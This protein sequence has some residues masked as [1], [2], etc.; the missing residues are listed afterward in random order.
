M[1]PHSE[2][3]LAQIFQFFKEF[4]MWIYVILIIVGII[5]IGQ[6]LRAWNEM[7]QAAFG[8][9]HE[10]AQRRLNRSATGLLLMVMLAAVEFVVVSFIIPIVPDASPLLLTPTLDVL[11]TPTTTLLPTTPTA[12]GTPGSDDTLSASGT[13]APLAAGTQTV[14]CNPE[15]IN[16]SSPAAGS[17]VSG[18]VEIQG[19]ADV[20]NFG[21]YKFEF[22]SPGQPN[23]QAILAWTSPKRNDSLGQWDTSRLQEGLYLLRLVVTDNQGQA[24][25]PCVI[26]VSVMKPPQ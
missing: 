9:E 23:W 11:A 24:Q 10:S 18:V 8:L 20:P 25:P 4:E 21:F 7:R 1:T 17:G 15:T 19:T 22:S 3:P 13:T 12:I 14:S 6:F 2:F 5:Y 16:I 26:Q